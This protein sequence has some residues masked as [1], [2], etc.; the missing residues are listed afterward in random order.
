MSSIPGRQGSPPGGQNH[1]MQ[2]RTFPV[3]DF[4]SGG[5]MEP[6]RRT[7]HVDRDAQKT[8]HH[9]QITIRTLIK[10]K[11]RSAPAWSRQTLPS[12]Q[13]LGEERPTGAGRRGRTLPAAARR[14]EVPALGARTASAPPSARAKRAGNPDRAEGGPRAAPAEQP[15]PTPRRPPRPAPRPGPWVPVPRAPRSPD[16][17]SRV[18][19]EG[20]RSPQR[21]PPPR[22]HSLT[23]VLHRASPTRT[24]APSS[25]PPPPPPRAGARR[26]HP[27]RTAGGPPAKPPPPPPPPLQPPPRPPGRGRPAPAAARP[28]G[29]SPLA[30]AAGGGA[31]AAAAGGGGGSRAGAPAV[32]GA[33]PDPVPHG[34]RR[35][36][37][38]RLTAERPREKSPDA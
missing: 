3:P 38:A 22:T 15:P 2:K 12:P 32:S 31:R 37:L 13:C 11:E 34:A 30:R 23:V 4:K 16:G 35:V 29:P 25:R 20:D 9:Q 6:P 14:A 8:R 36:G 18:L 27:P 28:P 26:P 24:L 19:E 5:R 10:G 21:A 7:A 33:R 1:T 17:N